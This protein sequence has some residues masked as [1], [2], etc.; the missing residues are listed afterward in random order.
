MP[1]RYRKREQQV[2]ERFERLAPTLDERGRRLFAAN[3]AMQFGYGGVEAVRRATGLASSTIV[4]GVAELG[5]LETLAPPP[6]KQRQPGAG[7][8]RIE[9]T[10]P[11]IVPALD[12]LIDPATLG[13]PE[14]P[15]RWT[16]KSTGK[17]ASELTEQGHPV[18]ADTV[19]RML[20][21][22]G[23]T[24]Q[25][26]RKS[27]VGSD[28][29]DRDAQFEHIN[30]LVQRFQKA[31]QPTISV[32]TKKKEL[33]GE[34]KNGGR[35]WHPKGEGPKVLT[36][37]FP[38]GMPKA[39]PY[40]VNDVTRNEGWVSIGV[41]SDTAEFATATIGRWW[42]QMGAK[43]YADATDVLITA[44]C[45]G[46][47][48]YRVRL[49]RL[50]LQHLADK[51]GLTFTVAHLPPGTSKWNKIEHRMFS[52]ISMNWR[53]RPLVSYETIVE[54]IGSTRTTKGLEIRCEID[55]GTYEKGRAV[56]D[57]ELDAILIERDRFHGEWNY[58][59][60]PR[61]GDA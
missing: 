45:G 19:A 6:G 52:F 27:K 13:D 31:G 59:I 21:D 53:G 4:R 35:E 9:E 8:K 51:T 44:D 5:D 38:N 11:G 43:A 58:T 56:S 39:V 34:Y 54:L 41:S 55:E 12:K 49:W 26:N 47:N 32:D 28:H 16:S 40:G 33:V 30:E 10:D 2:R 15:L 36:Y 42:E 48:G 24:L 29:V 37:D 20:K 25:A 23:F 46:S 3:E 7:G 14:S 61:T 17:L 57:T 1:S 50:E 18:S 22:R 60:Y